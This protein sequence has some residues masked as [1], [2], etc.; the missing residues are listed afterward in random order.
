MGKLRQGACGRWWLKFLSPCHDPVFF[1]PLF[2]TSMENKQPEI[3][4]VRAGSQKGFL[5]PTPLNSPSNLRHEGKEISLREGQAS[6]QELP[7]HVQAWL[8]ILRMEVFLSLLCLSFP[9]CKTRPV[10]PQGCSEHQYDIPDFS[11]RLP[12]KERENQVCV[13]RWMEEPAC[14]WGG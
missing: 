12:S 6:P 3:L 7:A 1:F 14:T 4:S 9:L 5:H 8:Q 11:L 2:W 13:G 10:L